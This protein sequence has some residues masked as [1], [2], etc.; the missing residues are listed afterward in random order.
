MWVTLVCCL[1][2]PTFGELPQAVQGMY[3]RVIRQSC[4]CHVTILG[5]PPPKVPPSEIVDRLT[6]GGSVPLQYY[7]VDDSN[8]GLGNACYLKNIMSLY[9]FTN[10]F[11]IIIRY[12]LQVFS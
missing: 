6:L 1:W 12:S 11:L 3:V 4:D 7:Y 8:K 2:A 10:F 5:S 9:E